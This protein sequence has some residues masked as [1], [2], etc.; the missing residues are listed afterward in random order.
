MTTSFLRQYAA[1][2]KVL[3]RE[4][5]E[6]FQVH[7][8]LG[9][10]EAAMAAERRSS[11]YRALHN[12]VTSLDPSPQPLSR[13]ARGASSETGLSSGFVIIRGSRD[14]TPHGAALF[15]QTVVDAAIRQG[16]HAC[17]YPHVYHHRAG[18]GYPLGNRGA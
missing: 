8:S 16:Y 14:L 17:R 12:Y 6:F 9:D 5:P 3:A 10:R 11:T 13:R 15:V 18:F 7:Y 2:A 1:I 4:K